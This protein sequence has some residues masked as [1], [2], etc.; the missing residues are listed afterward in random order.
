MR[1][2]NH[3]LER[4]SPKSSENI[5]H[6]LEYFDY[7]PGL[8][9]AQLDVEMHQINIKLPELPVQIWWKKQEKIIDRIMII[10]SLAF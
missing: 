7:S 5:D 10:S 1:Q 9:L 4:E 8:K 3:N 6:L 2:G